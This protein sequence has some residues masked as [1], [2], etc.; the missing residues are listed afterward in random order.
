MRFSASEVASATGGR[1][2]GPDATFDGASIDSR[3]LRGGELFVPVV[4]A[5][6]G[7]DFIEAAL[8]AGAGGY[9]SA[10][11]ARG[12]TAVLVDDTARAFSALGAEARDRLEGRVVGVT[13]SVGKT[14]TKDMLAAVLGRRWRAASSPQSFNNELGVPLTL[15]NAPD[16]C[17]A[18]VVEMGARGS[19]HIA[20]LC[21]I[22]RPT[23]GIVTAVAAVHTELFGTLDDVAA[24]KSELVAS[25]PS[26]GVA[27]LNA[28]D[29]RV[30]AMAACTDGRVVLYGDGDGAEIRAADVSVADDLRVS[31]RLVTPAGEV[32]VTIGARGAH[33]VANAL[34]AAAA[35]LACDVGLD[36]VAAGL[37]EATLSRWRM[38]VATTRSGAIVINDAYNASPMSVAAAL[39]SLARLPAS[40]RIA[41]LG[42]MAELGPGADGEHARIA[43]L[44]AS[45]GIRVIAMAAPAYGGEVVDGVEGALAALGPL[46]RGDAVL[47][48]GSRV[49]G[50]ERVAAALLTARKDEAF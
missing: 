43:G 48:K 12:G 25:L 7:H 36:D 49:A 26:T 38:E 22:A 16:G 39:A 13:G 6:D 34:A 30:R 8:A 15:V 42:Q 2:D 3:V 50:L 29:P 37:A 21:R 44:A 14:S 35:G 18:A 27:V 17:E 10:R 19:G 1:V 20:R 32:S 9:L 11:G 41:V 23:V 45:L 4:A 5:R 31:M 33:Q 28:D 46:G 24:A 40:R 47:V